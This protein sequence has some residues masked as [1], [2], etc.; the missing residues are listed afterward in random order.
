VQASF[1][2]KGRF[3]KDSIPELFVYHLQQTSIVSKNRLILFD[4][5]WHSPQANQFVAFRYGICVRG[6][7]QPGV[8]IIVA[9]AELGKGSPGGH[10]GTEPGTSWWFVVAGITTVYLSIDQYG[11]K[12]EEI[13]EK[14]RKPSRTCNSV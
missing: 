13:G 8:G 5:T 12:V 3:G 11:N 2:D 10:L 7:R 1:E 9:Y 14:Q 6:L 4:R